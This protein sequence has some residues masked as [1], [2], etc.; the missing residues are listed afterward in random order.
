MH[1][2]L[3]V[4]LVLYVICFLPVTTFSEEKNPLWG[5]IHVHQVEKGDFLY[6]IGL[7]YN[8]S[9]PAISRANGLSNSNEVRLGA[10]LTMPTLMVLPVRANDETIVINIPEFRLYHFR[11]ET[12]IRVYPICVGLTTW[13]T[14]TGPFEIANKVG[15]PTWYMNKE[16]ADKLHVK[17]E[18]IPPG[19]LNPLGDRW[20]GTSLKH[21]GIHS[22][23]QPM[24]IGRPLSHGCVRLYPDGAKELFEAV[25]LKNKGKVVYEPIKLALWQGDIYLE[26]H[27]DIYEEVDDYK[28]EVMR[29]SRVLGLNQD[30]LDRS[31]LETALAQKRGIPTVIGKVPEIRE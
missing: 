1:R 27:E 10:K 11:S 21:I 24:S 19:P 9:Y 30:L 16:M 6:K 4:Y 15:N 17:K 22:T 26:V 12:D 25:S 18:V 8:C 13:K 5:R 23:N 31:A 20:I 2:G 29:L 14:P 28:K 3:G 7:L